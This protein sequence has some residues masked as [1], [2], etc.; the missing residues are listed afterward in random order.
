MALL[1][2]RRRPILPASELSGFGDINF[3]ASDRPGTRSGFNEGQFILHYQLRA[4]E[5]RH[6]LR[7]TQPDGA[8][9]RRQRNPACRRLQCGGG[10]E[11]HPLRPE[12]PSEAFVRPLSHAHQLLEHRI[13]PRLLAADHRQPPG[14]DSVRREF[15]TRSLRRRAGRRRLLRG[16]PESQL[17][18]RSRQWPQFRLEPLRR[19][20]RRQQQQGV[21]RHAYSSSPTS[22]TDLQ[23]G[24]SVYRDK[25]DATGRPEA[26]EWIE[27]AHIVWTKENP[28]FIAEFFN[29]NHRSPG[30]TLATNSQVMVRAGCIPA[31]VVRNTGSP[32]TA[33]NTFTC[34]SPMRSFAAST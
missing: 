33:T 3:S 22:C 28:E 9:R 31:A 30:S 27:S 19:F 32:T 26:R 6:L 17:Q 13:P 15:H 5:P 12:R 2:N 23:V 24:G 20:W 21:A 29:V 11:H 14:D 7:G 16:R 10:T 25:I 1:S 34:R 4:F 8:D 18:R